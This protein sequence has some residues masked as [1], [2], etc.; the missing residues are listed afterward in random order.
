MQIIHFNS[1]RCRHCYKCVRNCEIK[2]I[3]LSSGTSAS[4]VS[5][6]LNRPMSVSMDYDSSGLPPE[7]HID[8]IDLVTEG[9]LT[10]AR[11]IRNMP[12]PIMWTNRFSR[13][14]TNRI[15]RQ[16]SQE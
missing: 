16:R 9:V 4:I 13:S 11:V 10:L 8:G 15:R 5:R 6:I 2:A 14:W 3:S 1:T 12:S 7:G